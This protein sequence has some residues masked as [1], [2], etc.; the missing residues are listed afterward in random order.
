MASGLSCGVVATRLTCPVIDGGNGTPARQ[1]AVPCEVKQRE[2]EFVC[3]QA[4][5]QVRRTA[6]LPSPALSQ[7]GH[8]AGPR[9]PWSAQGDAGRAQSLAAR[10]LA[11]AILPGHLLPPVVQDGACRRARNRSWS[12]ADAVWLQPSCPLVAPFKWA[13]PCRQELGRGALGPVRTQACACFP[14]ERVPGAEE[15][16]L[17]PR[18]CS[19]EP[20]ILRTCACTKVC[21]Y[22]GTPAGL[23]VPCH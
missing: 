13:R 7:V 18:R 14:S 5:R 2:D 8:L 6:H 21:L 17:W 16:V 4:E 15:G 22:K 23:G 1:V 12:S 10:G 20:L 19:L 3:P 9:G 11:F